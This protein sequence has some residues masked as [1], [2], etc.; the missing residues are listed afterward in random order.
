[1]HRN[2]QIIKTPAKAYSISNILAAILKA[3]EELSI[4]KAMYL[5]TGVNYTT[6]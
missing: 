4:H 1:M 3:L 2:I 6:N 5:M